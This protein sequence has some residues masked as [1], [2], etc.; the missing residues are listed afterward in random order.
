MIVCLAGG[1]QEINTGE[2]G[3]S[4][5]LHAIYNKCAEW[6]VYISP[7]LKDSEYRAV[8]TIGV[9]KE[10]CVVNFN[11]DWHLAVS[12][13]SYR[14]ENVSHFVKCLLDLDMKAAKE[15]LSQ[16]NAHNPIV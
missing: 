6:E 14:A 11:P 8:D 15:T 13:R 3:I 9:L 12:M 10:K 16:I 7:N 5:W 1:G 2:A 4:E